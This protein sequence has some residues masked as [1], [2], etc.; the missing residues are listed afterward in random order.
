MP[1]LR[2]QRQSRT[3]V[4]QMHGADVRTPSMRM[5]PL[6]G[7]MMRLSAIMS[8]LLPQPVRP[9][10]PTFSCPASITPHS[11]FFGMLRFSSIQLQKSNSRRGG[12]WQ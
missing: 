7:S 10:T 2:D 9:A 12:C 3:Q 4:R 8:V 1:Y 11:V 5:W 6:E